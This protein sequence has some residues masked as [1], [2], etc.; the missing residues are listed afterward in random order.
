MVR[1]SHRSRAASI[2]LAAVV[3]AGAAIST[4]GCTPVPPCSKTWLGAVSS[5]WSDPAN[6]VE[7]AVPG[8]TDR[9]CADV[10]STIVIDTPAS[11]DWV[12][13]SGSVSI[14]SGSSLT[15]ANTANDSSIDTLDLQGTITGTNSVRIEGATITNGTF[16]GSATIGLTG[17]H[18]NTI[19]GLTV[20]GSKFVLTGDA[21]W[22]GNLT[23]CDDAAFAV[24]ETV[25]AVGDHTVDSSGCG[26]VG[27]PRFGL[28]S[29]GT[30]N[31]SAG[32]L[33]VDAVNLW[34]EGTINIGVAGQLRA[35]VFENTKG[36]FNL[37]TSDAQ[38]FIN[39]GFGTM[40]LGIGTLTGAG[41][42]H[43]D[44]V[45]T[46]TVKPGFN[47]TG[48]LTIDGSFYPSGGTLAFDA[49]SSVPGVGYGTLHATNSALLNVGVNLVVTAKPGF[50][51]TGTTTMQLVTSGFVASPF[52][53]VSLPSVPG[54]GAFVA[55]QLTNASLVFTDCDPTIYHPNAVFDGQDLSGKNLAGCNLNGASLNDTNLSGANLD[56][57]NLT[58][59]FFVNTNF[60]NA[61]VAGADFSNSTALNSATN[62][63]ST[64][65]QGSGWTNTNLSST[66]LDLSNAP[67]S[68]LSVGMTGANLSGVNLDLATLANL[69][70]TA[71]NF[72]EANLSSANLTSANITNVDFTNANLSGASLS[73]ATGQPAVTIP[74]TYSTTTCPT[75]INSDDN[76]GNCEGQFN[77]GGGG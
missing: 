21:V 22:N 73:G 60:T 57:A 14:P 11:V 48:V 1:T 17:N 5:N 75:G 61:R 62:F 3:L 31:V 36:S 40:D 33:D 45:G 59:A 16:A 77:G 63:L 64:V 52:N 15:T 44:V 38:L 26:A 28:S 74:A 54:T 27:T 49:S 46:G 68:T 71:V 55:Y 34:N 7:N 66:N 13:L 25:D 2:G 20:A 19:S 35:G 43:G 51:A 39:N 53:T 50:T 12:T 76:A 10:G 47:D 56:G 67:L 18:P 4:A 70:L 69:D 30:V 37:T 9:A 32:T 41:T 23:L 29:T 24:A 42:V 58:E 6:W 65:S 8:P 72:S